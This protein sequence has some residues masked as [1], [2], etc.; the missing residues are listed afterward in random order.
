MN[1]IDSKWKEIRTSGGKSAFFY[2]FP[3]LFVF[4][5]GQ[6]NAADGATESYQRSAL[7]RIPFEIFNSWVSP[8][9]FEEF[10]NCFTPDFGTISKKRVTA[11]PGNPRSFGYSFSS[12]PKK[13]ERRAIVSRMDV[14]MNVMRLLNHSCGP[15]QVGV[16]FTMVP[17]SVSITT[18][19]GY[20]VNPSLN[21]A[22]V[23]LSLCGRPTSDG[24]TTFVTLSMN[25][26]RPNEKDQDPILR[27]LISPSELLQNNLNALFVSLSPD[28]CATAALEELNNE[29]DGLGDHF[30]TNQSGPGDSCSM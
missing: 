12:T 5:S 19:V 24:K 4:H 1:C 21:R 26:Q 2:F 11:L 20:Q 13:P 25:L 8:E 22:Y 18:S 7:S 10:L 28:G 17:T 6:S 30:N 29:L 16:S 23:K 3:L 15:S 14:E 27:A 9:N